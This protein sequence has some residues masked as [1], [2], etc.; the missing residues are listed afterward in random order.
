MTKHDHQFARAV[1]L[2]LSAVRLEEEGLGI[3]GHP[4]DL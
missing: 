1:R 3:D 4:V 2:E